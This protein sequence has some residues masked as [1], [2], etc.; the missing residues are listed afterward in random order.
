MK[1][2]LFRNRAGNSEGKHFI[3]S[4]VV[5]VCESLYQY[6]PGNQGIWSGG[7]AAAEIFRVKL[8]GTCTRTG[9]LM[10]FQITMPAAVQGLSSS[11]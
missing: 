8:Y 6:I 11:V 3:D 5:P 4:T 2:V 10:I 9:N 1:Y 7:R